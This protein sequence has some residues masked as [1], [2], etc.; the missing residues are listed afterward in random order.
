MFDTFPAFILLRHRRY[1]AFV[2]G[3]RYLADRFAFSVTSWGRT[4]AHNATLPGH[5]G[6][7]E[8][9]EWIAADVVFDAGADPGLDR[10][11]AAAREHGIDVI[12]E[13]D[14]YHLELRT[15]LD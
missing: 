14:H 11:K 9:L 15:T 2:L 3:V 7:S 12:R 6:D 5:A 4:P 13:A 1:L 10:F 8:H